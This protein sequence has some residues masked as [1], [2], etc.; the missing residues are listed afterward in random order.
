[1]DAEYAPAREPTSEEFA[2]RAKFLELGRSVPKTAFAFGIDRSEVLRAVSRVRWFLEDAG[3]NAAYVE[4]V[5]MGFGESDARL[6]AD[7]VAAYNVRELQR[8]ADG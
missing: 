7:T 2:V 3:W 8:K 4:A 1:M 6:R 5:R